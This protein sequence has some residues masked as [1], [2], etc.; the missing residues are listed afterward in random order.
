MAENT[1]ID[2]EHTEE[3]LEFLY[4]DRHHYAD[5]E[6][7]KNLLDAFYNHADVEDFLRDEDVHIPLYPTVVDSS[8]DTINFA[9]DIDGLVI[10]LRE[11]TALKA[12]LH[13]LV[14]GISALK[15][16]FGH[17]LG[18]V[19]GGYL[20]NICCVTAE[21]INPH[22]VFRT[23]VAAR[24]NAAQLIN[25]VIEVFTAKLKTLPDKEMQRPTVMKNNINDLTRMNILS[26]D[27][28]FILDIF[29]Q[30]I[31]EVDQDSTQRIVI[32]LSKFGQ[33]QTIP[34][35]LASLVSRQGVESLTCH[36]ACTLSGKDP[37]VDLLWSRYGLQEI[38]GHRGNLYTT[39]GIPE[40]AN[41]QS[42]LDRHPMTVDKIVL[43]VFNG[44]QR[45]D[46]ITF[47]QLYANT[48]H[49]HMTVTKHP[50]TLVI[51]TCGVHNK[52]HLRM[53]LQRAHSYIKCMDDPARKS[54]CRTH[55]RIEAVFLLN[56]N[57]PV[58][59]EGR[60]FF[61]PPALHTL[62]EQTPMVLPFKDN[63][64]G[65]GLRHVVKPVAT[66]LTSTLE[67][68]LRNSHSKGLGT[69]ST[70]PKS[71]TKRGFLGLSPVGSAS[72]GESPPPI[73]IWISD[74]IQRMRI[75]RIFPF[76]D[77]LEAGPAVIREA[78]V[79][80][81]LSDLHDINEG[82][83][84]QSLKDDAPPLLSKLV[85]CRTVEQLCRDLSER[86]GFDYPMTFGRAKEMARPAG[87]DVYSCL[88]LGTKEL[89]FF[90]AFTFWDKQRHPKARWNRKDNIELYKS[91]EAPSNAAEAAALLGDVCAEIEKR[92]LCY[93]TNLQRYKEN[94]MPW[95]E[96]VISRL[97]KTL[98][99]VKKIN[100][101]TLSIPHKMPPRQP[102][103]PKASTSKE[104]PKRS[105]SP[106]LSE[107]EDQEEVEME[108][109]I[110]RVKTKTVPANSKT[111]WSDEELKLVM[112][113]PGLS[114]AQ[115]LPGLPQG[116]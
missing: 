89:K 32:F 97:P 86:K 52:N 75:E 12:S 88:E 37:R 110:E 78:L 17:S 73:K 70:D 93:S 83:S 66:Y 74:P 80:V 72:V 19:D 115:A 58:R 22:P 67:G 18:F 53:I 28:N 71:L 91:T 41:F 29:M 30:A 81:I 116:M 69:L 98:E 43:D 24:A 57:I 99:R 107:Q 84:I 2:D 11:V 4:G 9:Y 5:V 68:L 114:H 95:M 40:A 92:G 94:G 55:A 15:K 23:E 36:A 100:T 85:G 50:V 101:L 51:A 6:N 109:V 61:H 7:A 60:D 48:P 10:E 63:S 34:L 33:K 35:D 39:T 16:T 104:P 26:D 62:L 90:P 65:L 113:N 111:M 46:K 47:L 27:Q 54:H 20:L 105:V 25:S 31:R 103:K 102:V 112:A 13:Y 3:E 21:K 77:T 79:R 49:V 1:L 45:Y 56:E 59:L 14:E 42:N 106:Q 108:Q 8:K 87:H 76:T 38:V 96:A 64:H 44:A 82:I